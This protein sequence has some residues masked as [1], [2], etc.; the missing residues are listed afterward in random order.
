MLWRGQGYGFVS[1]LL[2]ARLIRSVWLFGMMHVTWSKPDLPTPPVPAKPKR[3][4]SNAPKAFEG[5]T[6]KP[7]CALCERG[8]SHLTPPSPVPPEP[9]PPTNRR[10]RTVDTSWASWYTFSC[11][12]RKITRT[13]GTAT[14]SPRATPTADDSTL[15]LCFYHPCWPGATLRTLEGCVDTGCACP[16]LHTGGYLAKPGQARLC[17]LSHLNKLLPGVIRD[18]TPVGPSVRASAGARLKVHP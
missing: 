15:L 5:L 8:T 2:T 6:K 12:S 1:V 18:G 14:F 13:T 4:R 7:H 9:M 3:P 10:P 17:W 11:P 16:M